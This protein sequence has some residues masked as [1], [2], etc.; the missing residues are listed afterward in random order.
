MIQ[1]VIHAVELFI[2]S[3]T[4][5]STAWDTLL[6]IAL[7]GCA[8]VLVLGGLR[9][10]GLTAQYAAQNEQLRTQTA[11]LQAAQEQVQSLRQELD[12]RVREAQS[13]KQDSGAQRKKNHAMQEEIKRLRATV[14]E[15][16][17]RRIAAQNSRPAFAEPV[18]KPERTA[19]PVKAPPVIV[20]AAAPVAPPAP[21][22]SELALTVQ[23]KTLESQLNALQKSVTDERALMATLKDELRKTRKRAEDLRRIDI[24]T[25]SKMEVLEDKVADLGR[26]NYEAIS[27][28]ALLKGEVQPPR[29]KETPRRP[30]VFET[31]AAAAAETDDNDRASFSHDAHD[32]ASVAEP[33]ALL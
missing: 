22:P 32:A 23:I 5:G 28:L 11:A 19:P 21:G 10:R 13:L 14:R 12:D 26:A 30:S 2:V 31:D 29:P 3:S 7:V 1:H 16:T 8:T 9:Y 33:A 27:E 6:P 17:E 18:S 15:E 4:P 25:K 20:A 24:I